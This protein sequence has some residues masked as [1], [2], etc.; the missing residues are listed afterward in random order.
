ME[1][2]AK[3]ATRIAGGATPEAQ[4]SGSFV[5]VLRIRD[6][7]LLWLGQLISQTGD[8]FVYLALM[9]VISG[10]SSDKAEMT[11]SLSSLMIFFTLPKLLFGAL[12]GVFVDRWP[13][14]RT[15]VVA[16]LAR[17]VLTLAM[18]PA[19]QSRNLP[20]I[21]ALAFT[22]S[23]ISTFFIAAKGALLPRL[24]PREQLL[25]ANTISQVSMMVAN[26]AG[27]ALAGGVFALVGNDRQWVAFIV[28][29]A[30]FLLSGVAL[31]LMSPAGDM[32][33]TDQAPP[34]TRAGALRRIYDDLLVG[35]KV[36]A[37]NR[38]I[39]ALVV[40]CAIAFF[41]IG[42]LQVM[43]VLLLNGRFGFEGNELA[44][45]NSIVD[46]A[47]C[48][49]MILSS[50]VVGNLLSGVSPKWLIVWG[51]VISGTMTAAVGQ[52]PGYWTLVVATVLLGLAVA[53]AHAGI[54]TMMQIVVPN[55]QLGRVSGSIS[56]VSE[57]ALLISLALAGVV[58][59]TLGVSVAFLVSGA[60]CVIGGAVAWARLPA[61][62]AEREVQ[63]QPQPQ[64][65]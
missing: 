26:L 64:P 15:M 49:G 36:L 5:T 40:V 55:H 22:S 46:V 13:Q 38:A 61:I 63:P 41:A 6:F 16:D 59:R 39:S 30:S 54:S 17:M 31:W 65:Q 51:L 58:S 48:V 57:A 43:W 52:L 10:F 23:A 14:R 42:A 2:E 12:A 21:Y 29:A 56:T 35:L 27:P 32:T 34:S 33:R 53:P 19:F 62:K 37:L 50:V 44:W 9:V 28:D 20:L 8:Y 3:S 18:I 4:A 1:D 45:R 24:V 47:F 25:P 11:T 60:L 7:R